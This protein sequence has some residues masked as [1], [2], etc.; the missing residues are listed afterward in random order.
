MGNYIVCAAHK[1]VEA[2]PCWVADG[3]SSIHR[4]DLKPGDVM[5]SLKR[6]YDDRKQFSFQPGVCPHAVLL[7][8]DFAT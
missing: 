2:A 8:V 5:V 7:T 6:D 4:D 1:P 3:L